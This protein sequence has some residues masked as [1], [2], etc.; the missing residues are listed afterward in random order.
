MEGEQPCCILVTSVWQPPSVCV[1]FPSQSS[2]SCNLR[3]D[4]MQRFWK[5][6]SSKRNNK[7]L[8][9]THV[10]GSELSTGI[11]GVRKRRSRYCPLGVSS[12]IV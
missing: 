1:S 9:N 12:L 10:P 8:P 3:D 6:T 11:P 2:L 7:L 4:V 5:V